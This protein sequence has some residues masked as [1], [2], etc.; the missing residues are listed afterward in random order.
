M[1]KT[2]FGN[3]LM[4]SIICLFLLSC[5]AS[6]EIVHEGI[7]KDVQYSSGWDDSMTLYFNDGYVFTITSL[8]EG[9]I[10][11]IYIGK[12]YKIVNSNPSAG[13][14]SYDVIRGN[15]EN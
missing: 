10:D 11:E 5:A 9:S 13:L 14:I 4:I 2:I 7:L 3:L 6:P 15:G 8:H 12:Y 1:R